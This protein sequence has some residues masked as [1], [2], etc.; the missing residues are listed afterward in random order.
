MLI[1]SW[2]PAWVRT[3]WLGLLCFG[4]IVGIPVRAAGPFSETDVVIIH[5]LHGENIGDGYGWVG[6]ALGDLD[7]DGVEDFATTAPFF[8]GD[9]ANGKIYVYSGKSGA[10]LHEA[11]GVEG[12]RLGYSISTAGDFNQDGTPDYIV[13]GS[14][15]ANR[16]VV[17]SG[18]DHTVLHEQTSPAGVR[19]NFGV[20]VAGGGDSNGDGQVD[21]LVGANRADVSE[22]ITDTGRVYLLS[23][24]D[25]AVL[26][27]QMGETPQGMLGSGLGLVGD[28]NNDN[29]PDYV[30]AAPGAGDNGLGEA[31]LLSGVDGAMLFTLKPVAEES[32]GGTYGTFFASG[33]GDINAD[34]TPDIFVGDYAAVRGE[35]AN[36][37]RA[38]L[39]SGVDGTLLHTFEAEMDGDGVGPGRG[40]PDINGDGHADVSLAAWQS[41]AATPKGGKVYIH[42]GKNGSVLHTITGTIEQDALGVDALGVGDLNDD[43]ALDYMLTAVGNDFN[44]DDVGHIYI[45]ALQTKTPALTMQPALVGCQ[46]IQAQ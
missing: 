33:A 8:G 30:T 20:S 36:T 16:I 4:L 22:T 15:P 32:S 5:A 28:V 13:G 41:S 1:K 31:Y 7:G 14:G 26:W 29:I 12:N 34:G 6:A 3:L 21:L 38:Y 23:G 42:S 9:S 19:E 24:S 40:I 2:R 37:G 39:Y 43:G 10:L 25:G 17:Y 44:G 46:P 35:A 11:T 27:E 18:A 45:V